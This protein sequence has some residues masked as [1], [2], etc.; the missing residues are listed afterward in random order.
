MGP[1]PAAAGVSPVVPSVIS[2]GLQT[3]WLAGM[4]L[5]G[6]GTNRGLAPAGEGAAGCQRTWAG[7]GASGVIARLRVAQQHQAGHGLGLQQQV[8]LQLTERVFVSHTEGSHQQ[9]GLAA[10]GLQ[11]I[12]AQ[13]HLGGRVAL[14]QGGL[15]RL[16]QMGGPLAHWAGRDQGHLRTPLQRAVGQQVELTAPALAVAAVELTQ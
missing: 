11:Q 10:A 15:Q 7:G 16:G 14:L 3:G 6:I 9:L 8:L 12:A 2:T 13:Q 4:A 5:P 1:L